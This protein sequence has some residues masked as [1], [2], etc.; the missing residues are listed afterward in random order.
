MLMQ[1]KKR[2]GGFSLLEA[3]LSIVII[4]AAGLGVV[5][6]FISGDKKN[7]ENTTQQIIEQA[8]SAA[9]QLMGTSYGDTTAVSTANLISSG[10]MSK[11]Y[12]SVGKDASTIVGPYGT[13]EA[14]QL[15]SAEYTINANTVPGSAALTICQNMFSSAA[16]AVSTNK[17]VYATSLADCATIFGGA[18]AKPVTMNFSFPREDFITG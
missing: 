7:K 12:V 8:A 16:V 9:S 10:L 18:S 13:I 15:T 17:A 1:L 2:Q 5:E 4:L 11:S 14:T 3:L 6:L